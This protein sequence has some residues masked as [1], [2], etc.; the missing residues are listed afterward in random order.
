MIF[1]AVA[2]CALYTGTRADADQPPTSR[3]VAPGDTLWF[4]AADHYPHSEDPR[5]A[6]EAIREANGLDGYQ[7]QPGLRLELP[8]LDT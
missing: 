2:A 7:I 3:T 1:V 6:I 8:T 5:V 4:I